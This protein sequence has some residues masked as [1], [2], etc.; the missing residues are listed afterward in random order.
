VQCIYQPL[1]PLDD[2]DGTFM[3]SNIFLFLFLHRI[4]ITKEE[5]H[6]FLPFQ[7]QQQ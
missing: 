7:Q 5:D 1:L 2:D 3:Y 6:I 4:I